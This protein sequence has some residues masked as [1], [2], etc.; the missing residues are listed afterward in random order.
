MEGWKVEGDGDGEEGKVE[1]GSGESGKGDF[2]KEKGRRNRKGTSFYFIVRPNSFFTLYT[3]WNPIKQ[4][5]F[6]DL[7]A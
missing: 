2:K 6:H 1:K 3:Q 7:C 4:C 5:A